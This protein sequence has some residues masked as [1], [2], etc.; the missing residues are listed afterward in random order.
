M[1]TAFHY[2]YRKQFLIEQMYSAFSSANSIFA[3]KMGPLTRQLT[4]DW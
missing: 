1:Y 3:A 2:I 4:I